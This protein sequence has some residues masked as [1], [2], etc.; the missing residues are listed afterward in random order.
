MGHKL[1]LQPASRGQ[2]AVSS[3]FCCLTTLLEVFIGVLWLLYLQAFGEGPM[4]HFC[5]AKTTRLRGSS[6]DNLPVPSPHTPHLR[7]KSGR[8]GPCVLQACPS[9]AAGTLLISNRIS[10]NL[11]SPF[12]FFPMPTC[13]P[14][15][16]RSTSCPQGLLP[17]AYKT[18]P[19]TTQ[20]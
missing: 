17:H 12:P 4:P 20:Q 10:K 11:P 5:R 6:T 13:R 19:L 7:V 8:L 3:S 16:S 9:M 14:Q 2:R 1:L 15:A 18:P